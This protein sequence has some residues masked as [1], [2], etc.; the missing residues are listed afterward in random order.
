MTKEQDFA[1]VGTELSKAK[2]AL[3]LAYNDLGVEMQ[4][5]STASKG[6]IDA[7]KDALKSLDDALPKETRKKLAETEGE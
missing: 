2:R 4:Q 1:E 3:D 6:R 7:V 5:G